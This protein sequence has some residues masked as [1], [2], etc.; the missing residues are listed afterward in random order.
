MNNKK[1]IDVVAAIIEHSSEILAVR[2]GPSKFEYL[3]GKFE[4]PG[5]KVEE[6]ETPQQA[7]TREIKE[8]LLI[9]ITVL[10]EFTT[11]RHEYPDF[12]ITMKCFRCVSNNRALTLTEHTDYR[13]LPV[14][15]LRSVEWA[16]ADIPVVD[17]LMDSTI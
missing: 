8:E 3:S 13:W 2:R 12:Q 14:E 11:V 17:K 9:D 4:F 6:G 16:S 15:K 5:G 10:S 7:I 1:K